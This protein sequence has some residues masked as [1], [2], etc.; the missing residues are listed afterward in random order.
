MRYPILVSV[1]GILVL[2]CQQAPS[3]SVSAGKP[4]TKSP[5]DK[6]DQQRVAKRG[7][8]SSKSDD[9]LAIQEPIR[10]QNLAVFPVLSKVARDEDR[11]VTLDE[12]LKAGAVQVF[13]VGAAHSYD[14]R[15]QRQQVA[16]RS[17]QPQADADGQVAEDDELLSSAEDEE[18]SGE[19]DGDVNRL[20]VLNTSGKPL[21]LMPGETIVGGKQ[22][23]CIAKET[24]IA[25]GDVPVPIDVYCVEHGR[26]SGRDTREAAA[27]VAR[28]SQTDDPSTLEDLAQQAAGGR[29]VASAGA[30]NKATRLSVHEQEDQQQVWDGVSETNLITGATMASGAFTSNYVQQD[31][32]EK[33]D[34]YVDHLRDAVLEQDRVVGVIVAIDGKVEAADVFGSTPLFR[35]LWPKLLKSYALDAM[36]SGSKGA[37]KLCTKDDAQAFLDKAMRAEVS[38]NETSGGLVCTTR[39]AEHISS[40]AC[41]V[42]AEAAEDMG[43]LGGGFGAVHTSAFSK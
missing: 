33:L 1:L 12:G 36:S 16:V 10:H 4:A 15:R 38:K 40:F 5:A 21:Y 28:L 32:L 17:T 42:D 27:M 34:P 30:L 14:R 25:T 26:W 2:G 35:K 24:I 6:P 31:V 20:L 39:S 8:G 29:F 9:D 19:V 22:D 13:E 7:S 3:A 18:F 43:G 23:R 41:E 37:D 11:F